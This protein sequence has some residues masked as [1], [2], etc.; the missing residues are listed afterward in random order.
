M[1]GK[2]TPTARRLAAISGIMLGL[3][4]ADTL[5]NF[6][7]EGIFLCLVLF[8]GWILFL[9]LLLFMS[10]TPDEMSL[11]TVEENL[12]QLDQTKPAAERCPAPPLWRPA[13]FPTAQPVQI[14]PNHRVI[15]EPDRALVAHAAAVKPR[16]GRSRTP[17]SEQDEEREWA[18]MMR[19]L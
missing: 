9:R 5:Y 8:F 14:W 17:R 10:S 4:V 13:P 19:V 15:G 18:E 16:P 7:V 1:E 11:E 2:P 3:G 12:R 6:G